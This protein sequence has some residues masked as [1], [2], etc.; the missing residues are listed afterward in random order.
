MPAD[1]YFSVVVFIVRLF[2]RL[3]YYSISYYT[4]E[5]AGSWVE[6]VSFSEQTLDGI[7]LCTQ[8]VYRL[9][10]TELHQAILQSGQRKLTI[11]GQQFHDAEQNGTH[12]PYNT[13]IT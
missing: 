10:P 9:G 8:P 11:H 13:T 5:G 4:R 7:L 12:Q 2:D 1:C 3:E 6:P